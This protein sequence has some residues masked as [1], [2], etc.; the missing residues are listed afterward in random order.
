[1]CTGSKNT[2]PERTPARSETPRDFDPA[3]LAMRCLTPP[4][5]PELHPLQSNGLPAWQPP[6]VGPSPHDLSLEER[7]KFCQQKGY[8]QDSA[9]EQSQDQSR[10]ISCKLFGSD[11]RKRD[12]C[13]CSIRQQAEQ[14]EAAA[15]LCEERVRRDRLLEQQARVVEMPKSQSKRKA[16]SYHETRAEYLFG[17]L[18]DQPSF[19]PPSIRRHPDEFAVMGDLDGYAPGVAEVLRPLFK[20]FEASKEGELRRRAEAAKL[21]QAQAK[22]KARLAREQLKEWQK[23]NARRLAWEKEEKERNRLARRA[24]IFG[25]LQ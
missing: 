7:R 3:G 22:E 20:S 5:D 6:S 19:R 16:E 12:P 1:M 14:A 8:K 21:A 10:C 24:A 25:F 15:R 11:P 4:Y 17:M 23:A 9:G 18:K 2:R 13:P